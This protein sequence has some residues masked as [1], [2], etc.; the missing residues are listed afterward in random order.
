MPLLDHFHPPL[1]PRRGWH[2]FHGYWPA[3]IVDS[4]NPS[5]PPRYA[6]EPQLTLASPMIEIDVGAIETLDRP[7][8]ANGLT[9]E[10]GEGG[11]AVAKWSPPK[12]SLAIVTEPPDQDEFEVRV[13]DGEDTHRLVA[14]IE[15]VSP[16][17]K[18]R[19]S[20]RD[21]FVNKCASLLQ[22]GVCVT[23]VDVV[24]NR[25]ANLYG[26][27]MERI[28]QADPAFDGGTP[29]LYAVT[30]RW[31]KRPRAGMLEVWSHP[32]EVGN[33]LPT[34]PVWLDEDLAIPLDLEASY[35]A[36]RKAIR[37]R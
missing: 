3:K 31:A 10:A 21:A 16:A 22:N 9:E 17:N 11:I 13:Y 32:L 7:D 27:L 37:Y 1:F 12:P 30:C 26:E 36:T 19:P 18:D 23:I 35:E 8:D 33:P 14:A 28:G 24:T 5:M 6:A 4:L 25:S 20:T 2:G 29:S 15:L 34:L